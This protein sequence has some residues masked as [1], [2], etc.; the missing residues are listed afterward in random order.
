[1]I[2]T[3]GYAPGV[4]GVRRQAKGDAALAWVCAVSISRRA[5]QAKAA[6]PFACRR[7]PY[8]F[9]DT[10]NGTLGQARINIAP[11]GQKGLRIGCR[12]WI[13]RLERSRRTRSQP[14]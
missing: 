6:S 8:G 9:A 5:H 1:M 7:T 14:Y 3:V 11:F 12:P 4:Y 2:K 13:F 10:F